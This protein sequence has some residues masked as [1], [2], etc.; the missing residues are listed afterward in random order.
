MPLSLT[1]NELSNNMRVTLNALSKRLADDNIGSAN[2]TIIEA[3]AGQMEE[4]L[5]YFDQQIAK[6]FLN[7]A[8]GSDLDVLAYDRYQ[9]VR[10]PPKN[11]QTYVTVGKDTT[12]MAD[13]IGQRIP[14]PIG[15]QFSTDP[16]A[17]SGLAVTFQT[18]QSASILVT[19]HGV[20]TVTD[21]LGNAIGIPVECTTPGTIGNSKAN[22][23]INIITDVNLDSVTNIQAASGGKNEQTDSDFRK[24]IIL[25]LLTLARGTKLALKYAALKSNLVTSASVVESGFIPG[26]LYYFIDSDSG[27]IIQY[28]H[29]AG[30]LTAGKVAVYVDDGGSTPTYTTMVKILQDIESYRAAGTLVLLAAPDVKAIDCSLQVIIDNNADPELTREAIA[31]NVSDFFSN[32]EL[33][34]QLYIN[35]LISTVLQVQAVRNVT[36]ISPTSDDLNVGP[37]QV[38][39]LRTL[40]L[41]QVEVV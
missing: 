27:R 9:L 13:A 19:G 25:F 24:D 8:I 7:T 34:E 40:S 4:I 21:D 36:V 6:L 28:P 41:T 11:A 20:D 10:K 30:Q 32:L 29:Q 26:K 23:I 37:G 16:D 15:T 17:I 31:Q 2:R 14:I 5:Y 35:Q 12:N 39:R 22:K 18:V 33:G 38:V 3:V 1:F